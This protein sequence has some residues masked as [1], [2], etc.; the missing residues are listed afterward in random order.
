MI[1]TVC[2]FVCVRSKNERMRE[3]RRKRKKREREGG[4]NLLPEKEAESGQRWCAAL[5][6][7]L[8]KARVIS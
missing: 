8:T 6:R 7:L 5:A 4:E 1:P 2:V 3:G